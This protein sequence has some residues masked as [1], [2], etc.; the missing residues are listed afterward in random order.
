[1]IAALGGEAEGR[2]ALLTG[3]VGG[4]FQGEREG[5]PLVEV[6]A[7]FPK[8]A[9]DNNKTKSYFSLILVPIYSIRYRLRI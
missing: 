8:Q 2:L 1:M 6:R 5:S 7:W 4:D 9:N 3:R